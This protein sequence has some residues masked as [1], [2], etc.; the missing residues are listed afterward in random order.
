MRGERRREERQGVEKERK[1]TGGK[2]EKRIGKERK[3]KATTSLRESINEN[4][5][6]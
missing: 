3:G 6:S 5:W 2:R 1:N 4:C